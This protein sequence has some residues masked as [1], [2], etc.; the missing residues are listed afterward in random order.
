MFSPVAAV[1]SFEVQGA[2]IHDA[3]LKLGSVFVKVWSFMGEDIGNS[4]PNANVKGPQISI[5]SI[6]SALVYLQIH[7]VS[8]LRVVVFCHYEC[9]AVN[10]MTCIRRLNLSRCYR[11][12]RSRYLRFGSIRLRQSGR[13]ARCMT[14]RVRCCGFCGTGQKARKSNIKVHGQIF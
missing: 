10:K 13:L 12:F 14:W 9:I 8:A 5:D 6:L 3:H 1:E 11:L 2:V 4:K 7:V